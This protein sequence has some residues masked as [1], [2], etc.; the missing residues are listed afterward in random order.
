MPPLIAPPSIVPLS[1]SF[2]IAG[3]RRCPL[4]NLPQSNADACSYDTRVCNASNDRCALI[5]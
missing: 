3:K 5:T 1:P 4:R 2:I